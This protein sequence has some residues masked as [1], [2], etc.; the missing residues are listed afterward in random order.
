MGALIHSAEA[1]NLPEP[2]STP[3]ELPFPASLMAERLDPEAIFLQHL[4]WIE[5]VAAMVCRRNTVWGDD[6]DDFI[7]SARAKLME[8]GYAVIRKFRGDAEMK[9]YL[10]RV[11]TLHFMERARERTGRWRPSAAAEAHGQL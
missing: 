8:N 10:A 4:G 5:E 7:S 1:V 6:A 3:A 9:T 11:V 2:T